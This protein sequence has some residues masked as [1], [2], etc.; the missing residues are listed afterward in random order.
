MTGPCPAHVTSRV[1]LVCSVVRAGI[2][3]YC[4][5]NAFL[6]YAPIG[7][8]ICTHREATQTEAYVS[9]RRRG[10][11]MSTQTSLCK[12]SCCCYM[13]WYCWSFVV[14]AYIVV[15]VAVCLRLLLLRFLLP[16][17]FFNYFVFSVAYFF[18]FSVR[19]A[20]KMTTL[21]SSPVSHD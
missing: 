20:P 21:F 15:L 3:T 7:S 12:P 19:I 9:Q 14:P 8:L 11:D 5:S 6:R 4:D 13:T 2:C 1:S 10:G 16:Y 18:D 17:Y